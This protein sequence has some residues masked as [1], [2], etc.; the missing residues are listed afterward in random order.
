M[1]STV[2]AA[3]G[4][5]PAGGVGDDRSADKTRNGLADLEG[6][7]EAPAPK[8]EHATVEERGLFRHEELPIS[9]RPNAESDKPNPRGPTTSQETSSS[10]VTDQQHAALNQAIDEQSTSRD[11]ACGHNVARRNGLTEGREYSYAWVAVCATSLA[12]IAPPSL[13][14]QNEWALGLLPLIRNNLSRAVATLNAYAKPVNPSG[15]TSQ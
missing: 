10:V 15:A 1:T 9:P 11:K 2:G 14:D 3:A 5:N 6:A 7:P 8:V 4:S 12:E 13:D